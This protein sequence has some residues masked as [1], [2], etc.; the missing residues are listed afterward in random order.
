MSPTTDWYTYYDLFL[1]DVL[2]QHAQNQTDSIATAWV[3]FW[4]NDRAVL[5]RL[6][7]NGYTRTWTHITEHYGNQ[8]ATYRYDHLLSPPID[9]FANGMILRG[10]IIDETDLRLDLW[11]STDTPQNADY[12]TAGGLLNE[13]GVLVAQWDSFPPMMTSQW[14]ENQ[15]IFDPKRLKLVE[16]QSLTA[17]E[18]TAIVKVYI[19]DGQI[20]DIRTLS[21]APYVEIG[22]IQVD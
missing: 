22:K 1:P 3:V 11:W 10:A 18:Y 7:N 6:E 5:D 17:G 8:I 13:A 2:S 21:D 14:V 20:T 4:S 16:G 9:T 15:V 12:T 19:W